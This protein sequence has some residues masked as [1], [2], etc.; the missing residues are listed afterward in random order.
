MAIA[1]RAF[2]S[3]FAANSPS[4][5]TL[6]PAAAV[7]GDVVFAH[8]AW[9]TTT[10]QTIT[11]VPAGWTLVRNDTTGAAGFSSAVYSHT[12]AAGEPGVTA[13]VFTF[14]A[15]ATCVITMNVYSGV[16]TAAPVDVHGGSTGVAGTNLVA[17]SVVTTRPDAW[18]VEFFG[19]RSA[20]PNTIT[21]PATSRGA[22]A[23]TI[24]TAGTADQSVP[25]PGATAT[26]TATNS[27][28]STGWTAQTVA[29]KPANRAPTAPAVTFP[30]GGETVNNSANVTWTPG[31]DPD[32][33]ALTYDIDYTRDNAANWLNVVTGYAAAQPYAWNTSAIAAS[34]AC[35]VRI[36]SRDPGGLT[37]AYDE[38]NANFTIQHNVAPT[39]AVGLSPDGGTAVDRT[40][41]QR[42]AWTFTDPDVGDTQSK[43][44]VQW[45]LA[46][47]SWT[48]VTQTTTSQFYD[49]PANTFPAGSIEWQVRTYDAL[50][51]ASPWSASAFFTA[52]TTPATPAITAP[53]NN[54]T[55]AT[56]A[57][58]LSWSA[59]TQTSY[60]VRK[61][62]DSAGAPNTAVVYYDSG[63]VV[64][65]SA[66]NAAL[67]F[68]V[69]NRTEHLQVRIKASGLW[70]T[71]SSVKVNVAYSA[72]A[73]PTLVV[74]AQPN[75]VP[76]SIAVAV[77]H[78]A[79][80]N[81]QPVVASTELWR[82][83]VG[84]G[85][86]GEPLTRAVVGGSYT[87]TTPAA[88]VA[89]EYQAVAIGT[90]TT[91]QAS[92]WTP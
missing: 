78:P 12:V 80:V 55:Q 57:G 20:T 10:G 58:V 72:P 85:S 79:P 75:A 27:V 28:A 81:P 2:S 30:N 40:L 19:S 77:T 41:V 54:S 53:A 14:S 35:R 52:A 59:P 51:V 29:I 49:A 90:T 56:P 91:K 66:R 39:A 21:P 74:T 82:R 36:R 45:R 5:S 89:Y 64:S 50:G 17:P 92:A 44:D 65:S 61:V 31:T 33:D 37:S 24:D 38:S 6:I 42:L 47:G 62:A 7:A 8:V 87:D 11:G 76:P 46:A 18:A 23:A 16:D 25:A 34:T 32:A 84:S 13:P 9:T 69:N 22:S 3:Q 26:Q 86:A 71:W 83:V 48:T 88:G 73:V 68:P 67:D 43:F 63:E 60:Q 4:A 70:S 1:S 15:N